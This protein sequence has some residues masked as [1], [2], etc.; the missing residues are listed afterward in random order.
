MNEE[1]EIAE[2]AE[3]REL[4]NA[5]WKESSDAIKPFREFWR[6]SGDMVRDEV[7]K[8]D[9]V[10]GGTTL[11]SDEVVADC[12][13]AVMRLHQF[14]HTIS[15]LSSGSIA[16]IQNDLCQRAMTD[17]VVRAMDAAKKAQRDM[18]TIYQWVAAA[19]RPNKA[20]Q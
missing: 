11:V 18:A 4:Y 10:L 16:K 20:Q 8:L 3:K 14:A 19:E 17:I 15:E 5:F 13:Q 1:Q 2:S 7:R 9:A 12:R 6:K